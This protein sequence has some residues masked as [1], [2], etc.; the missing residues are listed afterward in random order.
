MT[1]VWW[2]LLLWLRAPLVMLAGCF[3][4][5]GVVLFGKAKK[6]YW[7]KNMLCFEVGKKPWGG[8]SCGWVKVVD[9]W[10]DKQTLA[11]ESG[12]QIQLALIGDLWIFVVAIPSMVRYQYYMKHTDAAKPYDYAW[13]EGSA[14]QIGY[15]VYLKRYDYSWIKERRIWDAQHKKHGEL[16]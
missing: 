10:V 11:H 13:F 5:L 4:W 12:H 1:K 9:P 16:V 14:S 15:E 6:H 7:D 3:V 2:Q 8:F